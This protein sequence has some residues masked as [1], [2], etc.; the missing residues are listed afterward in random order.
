M[1]NLAQLDFGKLRGFGPL[2]LENQTTGSGAMGVFSNFISSAIG[3]IT[4]IAIIWFIFVFISGA[5]G[6]ISSGGDK[7]ALESAKKRITSGAIGLVV[8]IAGMFIIQ[9]IGRI[10]GIP[11]ILNIGALFNKIAPS[12]PAP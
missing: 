4:I 10:I 5:L 8:V 11:D 9:L 6:I 3:L 7:A 12:Q 1:K 2:G